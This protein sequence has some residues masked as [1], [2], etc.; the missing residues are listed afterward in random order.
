M[1]E[2]VHGSVARPLEVPAK[3]M[4]HSSNFLFAA[5]LMRGISR[6]HGKY[7]M[8]ALSG[9]ERYT[10]SA[11]RMLLSGRRDD[12]P[13]DTRATDPFTGVLPWELTARAALAHA[14]GELGWSRAF[15]VQAF[16]PYQ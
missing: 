4:V 8:A 13:F 6:W 10:L 1:L 9:L 11:Q 3:K 14:A 16:C 7:A 5:H 2:Y 12:T 15:R